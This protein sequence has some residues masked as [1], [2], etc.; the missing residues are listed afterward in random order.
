MR[1]LVL[2]ALL[3]GG[4]W[5][6]TPLV[7]PL[8]PAPEPQAATPVQTSNPGALEQKQELNRRFFSPPAGTVLPGVI[9]YVSGRISLAP[10]KVCAIPLLNVMPKG[11]FT[12]DPKIGIMGSRT[13]A[14]IDHMPLIRVVPPCTQGG[15]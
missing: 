3:G 6:Q 15:R 13:L 11:G 5:A 7:N 2:T 14:N 10:G 1:I 8:E 9:P 12:G 4:L